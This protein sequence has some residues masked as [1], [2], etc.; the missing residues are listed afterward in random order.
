MFLEAQLKMCMVAMDS[1]APKT[2]GFKEPTPISPSMMCR[3]NSNSSSILNA[4][5][6]PNLNGK[7]ILRR[8]PRKNNKEMKTFYVPL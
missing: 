1:R 8:K 4:E 3:Y 5:P 2:L 6:R 7:R